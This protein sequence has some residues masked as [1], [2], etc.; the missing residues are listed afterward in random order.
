[1]G[2]TAAAIAFAQLLDCMDPD[3]DSREPCCKCEACVRIEENRHLEVQMIRPRI[4]ADRR[5][6]EGAN[7]VTRKRDL[8]PLAPEYM[9]DSIIAI[10][11]VRDF[12]E[13]ASLK[14]VAGRRRVFI[15]CEAEKMNVQAQNCLLKTLEEPIPNLTIVLITQHAGELLPTIVSRCQAVRFGLVP[16]SEIRSLLK[17]RTDLSVKEIEFLASV[18]G[19]RPGWALRS[20]QNKAFL[21]L[22]QQVFDFIGTV[23]CGEN[24]DAVGLAER[25]MEFAEALWREEKQ[26]GEDTEEAL[27]DASAQSRILRSSQ[28]QFLE[29]LAGW[30]RDL[31][32]VQ[33]EGCSQ[34]VT[35]VQALDWLAQA[36]QNYFRRDLIWCIE[37]IHQTRALILANANGQ[38]AL[39][40]L[41]LNLIH[42][43]RH[44][45]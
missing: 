34:A 30:F 9:D 29:L 31:L 16:E 28:A 2:K 4:Y 33:H 14:P 20:A 43:R 18:S 27:S 5:G 39:E 19:G 11:I 10:E 37:Q 44:R 13:I 21:T 15:F 1:M 41:F 6:G 8:P 24:V 26:G 35:N 23:H 36:A 12:L 17:Q 42:R 25:A 3:L 40:V 22:R 38:L 45:P 7:D 32:L